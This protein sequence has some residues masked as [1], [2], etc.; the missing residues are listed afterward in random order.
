L[1]TTKRGLFIYQPD[2][3]DGISQPFVIGH[4]ADGP[5]AV[6]P[7]RPRKASALNQLVRKHPSL[8]GVPFLL[9][10]VGASYGM[11]I[12]T[13]TRYDLHDQKVKNVCCRVFVFLTRADPCMPLLDD[14]RRRAEVEER[15]KKI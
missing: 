4:G 14:E 12:F 9:L 5:M 3:A 10:M 15:Q 2:Y 8:F 1:A 6:F 13:Q 11:T 7:S